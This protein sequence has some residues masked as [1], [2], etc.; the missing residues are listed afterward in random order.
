MPGPLA[1]GVQRFIGYRNLDSGRFWIF[2]SETDI[3]HCVFPFGP[4]HLCCFAAGLVYNACCL[5]WHPEL[6][7]CMWSGSHDF[8]WRSPNSDLRQI[9]YLGLGSTPT[10][11]DPAVGEVGF[12]F[13]VFLTPKWNEQKNAWKR[14]LRWGRTNWQWSCRIMIQVLSLKYNIP[15]SLADS[16]AQ[17]S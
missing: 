7:N 13:F 11:S 12:R 8:P 5:P 16:I 14:S 9:L 15:I 4:V 2:L 3:P 6:G 10:N 17:K 1:P